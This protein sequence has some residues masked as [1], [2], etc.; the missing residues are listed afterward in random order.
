MYWHCSHTYTHTHTHTHTH[1]YTHIYI[2]IYIYIYIYIWIKY[3]TKSKIGKHIHTKR[4]QH[5]HSVDIDKL[6]IIWKFDLSEKVKPDFFK[7]VTMS[8]LLYRFTT[9][10]HTKTDREK[11]KHLKFDQ[12]VLFWTD[13]RSNTPQNISCMST[14][15]ASHK[16]S[17]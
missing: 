9:W 2:N 16:A 15:F 1:T 6:S 17:K 14:Y 11:A 13:P 4:Y 12:H 8:V 3:L 10:N 7:A 5:T